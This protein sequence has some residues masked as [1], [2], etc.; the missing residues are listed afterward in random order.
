MPEFD[1]AIR[2]GTVV[3]ASDTVRADVGVRG[4]RIVA[5]AEGIA[6]AARVIDASGLLVLPGGIDSHVH[7]AQDPGPGIVM[8]DDFASATRAAAAGGNTCVMPFAVQPRGGSLRGAVDAYRAKAEGQ[9]HV[10][11]AIHMIIADPSEAVLGQELPALVADGYTSFKVFMTYDDLVLNDRQLL[12]VFHVARRQGA[13]VMVHA[14]GYDAIRYLSD[15]LERAGETAPYG[16]ALSRPEVVEREAAHRAISHA[17]LIDLPIVIV[18]VSGREATEQIAWAQGRGLKIRAETCPQY[19]TLTAEHM[20]GLGLD[21]PMAGAKYVCSPPPRDEASQEAVW[22]GIRRGIFDVVSSDHSPFRYDDPQ[23]KLNPRG[24]SSFRWIPNGIPGVE[25][26]LP[27][28]FSE[29]VSKGRI[30]LNQF[31]AL[32]ATNHAKLYGLYPRKGSIAPG[33]DADLTLWD[34]NKRETIR[35]AILHHGAD[36]TPWEGFA[37]TG[38]P[39]MTI[40]G[41]QV[42]AEDGKVLSE[43]G[44]GRVL[45]RAVDPAERQG[46]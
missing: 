6:D 38:W 26:R 44:R 37:V 7:I 8:A 25:T 18:H 3:T 17:E 43:P 12:D 21:D 30:S 35:Q 41:G 11:V 27:V 33:F 24:K 16:H 20:K 22:S 28:F 9:C 13:R 10:D 31:A 5:V 15:R 45:D 23:G 14:E 39:V 4:G 36:Y 2:G 42:I 1:L 46:A 34:P 40:A 29:G 32:T 19:L